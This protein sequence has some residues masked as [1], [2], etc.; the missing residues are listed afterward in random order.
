MPKLDNTRRDQNQR[1]IQ[2]LPENVQIAQQFSQV[3]PG[4]PAPTYQMGRITAGPQ[5]EG[6]STLDVIAGNLDLTTPVQN[7]QRTYNEARKNNQKRLSEQYTSYNNRTDDQ[8]NPITNTPEENQQFLQDYKKKHAIDSEGVDGTTW[9]ELMYKSKGVEASQY[10]NDLLYDIN[11]ELADESDPS[12]QV[13]IINS[14]M[15]KVPVPVQQELRK[16][17][18]KTVSEVAQQNYLYEQSKLEVDFSDYFTK[19]ITDNVDALTEVSQSDFTYD[20]AQA[21]ALTGGDKELALS[22]FDE[23][24]FSF[25]IEKLQNNADANQFLEVQEVED[26]YKLSSRI[27]DSLFTQRDKIIKGR[28]KKED[29]PA[30]SEKNFRDNLEAGNINFFKKQVINKFRDYAGSPIAAANALFNT[31][32]TTFDKNDLD[33]ARLRNFY[34]L[35]PDSKEFMRDPIIRSIY[36][37]LLSQVQPMTF[38]IN[39]KGEYIRLENSPPE[40]D[41][42][43]ASLKTIKSSFINK[44]EA[45]NYLDKQEISTTGFDGGPV[46]F[47]SEKGVNLLN[48]KSYEGIETAFINKDTQALIKDRL[49][50]D[51]IFGLLTLT[52]KGSSKNDKLIANNIVKQMIIRTGNQKLYQKLVGKNDEE[53]DDVVAKIRNDLLDK[54]TNNSVNKYLKTLGFTSN[55]G[56]Q[57]TVMRLSGNLSTILEEKSSEELMSIKGTMA[58]YLINTFNL[59]EQQVTD[60]FVQGIEQYGNLSKVIFELPNGE[61][62]QLAD[63]IPGNSPKEIKFLEELDEMY[64]VFT[65]RAMLNEA[66]KPIDLTKYRKIDETQSSEDVSSIANSSSLEVAKVL[67]LNNTQQVSPIIDNADIY[68]NEQTGEERIFLSRALAAEAGFTRLARPREH[69]V[70]VSHAQ[71]RALGEQVGLALSSGR[72]INGFPVVSNLIQRLTN[73]LATELNTN[74]EIT[75]YDGVESLV[76]LIQFF[77]GAISQKDSISSYRQFVTQLA[78]NMEGLNEVGAAGLVDVIEKI[79]FDLQNTGALTGKI[80]RE[81]IENYVQR[82]RNDLRKIFYGFIT[83]PDV[84]VSDIK[85]SVGNTFEDNMKFFDS[86]FDINEDNHVS[87]FMIDAFSSDAFLQTFGVHHHEQRIKIKSLFSGLRKRKYDGEDIAPSEILYILD[88]PEGEDINLLPTDLF[89][90]ISSKGS[91][92]MFDDNRNSLTSGGLVIRT[93]SRNDNTGGA[94]S[95]VYDDQSNNRMNDEARARRLFNIVQEQAI[96]MFSNNDVRKRVLAFETKASELNK[97]ALLDLVKRDSVGNTPL[98]IQTDFDR[99]TSGLLH[100]TIAGNV[101]S[102]MF[103]WT[104]ITGETKVTYRGRPQYVHIRDIPN[105]QARKDLEAALEVAKIDS[106][107]TRKNV[108]YPNKPNGD[109]KTSDSP[110]D[111]FYG[112][113]YSQTEAM[114]DNF[115]NKKYDEEFIDDMF[116][117]NT[118]LNQDDKNLIQKI[119]TRINTEG[120]DTLGQAF[121]I[122]NEEVSA[123]RDLNL[124]E[125]A[126]GFISI[127]KQ[128]RRELDPFG[129]E[130]DNNLFKDKG[131]TDP[132]DTNRY[133]LNVNFASFDK[134]AEGLPESYLPTINM[135]Q[136]SGAR[137]QI[138]PFRIPYKYFIP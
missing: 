129:N 64:T 109:Y 19:K 84:N 102:D 77:A 18:L 63:L 57:T 67:F 28:N 114:A 27:T 75:T 9:W 93:R 88:R 16:L 22:F 25:D 23:E 3:T 89:S 49:G 107:K 133:F 119:K 92:N 105:V 59:P 135:V 97:F 8:G 58:G 121:L 39:E 95:Y 54:V 46:L 99:S 132:K 87:Y 127:L 100:T 15:H 38:E 70:I 51:A 126:K 33:K 68:K 29:V 104:G 115:Y 14:Y 117:Q 10:H 45:W 120:I 40:D 4:A 128:D 101:V 125:G 21:L 76:G 53:L 122:L 32:Q 56:L 43:W 108:I 7:F 26:Y 85:V 78:E 74:N 17:K 131:I 6:P 81:T 72:T 35:N 2:K 52:D 42:I 73:N 138:S 37:G 137:Y 123:V 62:A 48:P 94:A 34:S 1:P 103:D 12:N 79:H 96:G 124:S 20:F 66:N 69:T 60:F 118:K 111:E 24:T 80:D 61:K 98:I 31:Y 86:K 47:L 30:L 11:L 36:E 41:G 106:L 136:T 55:E 83:E 44:A 112:L 116:S 130:G 5:L 65:T 71:A 134:T 82:D 13:E 90:I 91:Y 113:G 110:N 50:E